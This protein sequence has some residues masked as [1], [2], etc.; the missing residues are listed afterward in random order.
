MFYSWNRHILTQHTFAKT[1]LG[2]V[3]MIVYF[4]DPITFECVTL[5][6]SILSS[7]EDRHRLTTSLK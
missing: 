1:T 4:I 7:L 6:M 2:L 5:T 3:H